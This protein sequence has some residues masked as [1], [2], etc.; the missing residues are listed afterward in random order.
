LG[1]HLFANAKALVFAGAFFEG[2]EAERWLATGLRILDR[3]LPEQILPDGGHFERSTMY[4][5]LAFEDMLDLIQPRRCLSPISRN[6]RRG[7]EKSLW[8]QYTLRMQRWLH[9]MS[10][11]DGEIAFFN[12]AALGV[13]PK[14][15]EL[16]AYATR[17]GFII[18]RLLAGRRVAGGQRLPARSPWRCGGIAGFGA[19]GPDYLPGHAHADTLSFELV[20]VRPAGAG[21]FGDLL[22][23][24]DSRAG[25]A[26]GYRGAQHRGGQR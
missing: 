1:N 20:P 19:V 23:R 7:P 10:H 21:E 12:D 11:P 2:E 4:H 13:A 6:W 22:L 8:P 17:L 24:G 16:D 18:R 26:T 5:A 9:A 14:R 15:F 3:E 25:A